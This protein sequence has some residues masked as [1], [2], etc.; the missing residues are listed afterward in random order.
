GASGPASAEQWNAIV[1]AAEKEGKVTLYNAATPSIQMRIKA[2]FEKAHPRITLE[3]VRYGSGALMAKIDQERSMGAEGADVAV[4]TETAWF[5]RHG[6]QGLV[7]A[8]VGPARAGWPANFLLNGMTPILTMEPIVMMVNTNLVKTPVTGQKDLIRP[9]FKGRIGVED[10]ASTFV[11]AWYD[12]VEKS[13]EPGYLAK[14]A[15][16]QPR[17]YASTVA[18]AQSVSAGE[19]AIANF[20][21]MGAALDAVSKGA[22]VR[23]VMP[24]PA[25]ANQYNAAILGWAR[26]SNAAQVLVNFLM[27]PAGQESWSGDGAS[28]SPLPNIPNALDARVMRSVDL[29]PYTPEFTKS[30]RVRFESM[31]KR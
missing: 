21:N 13:E 24:N 14:L 23:V 31:F 27:S 30:Y 7:K 22:P 18:G 15:A 16:Q 12:L 20:V 29:T 9:E 3:W 28:G 11:F 8:P 26:R 19:I 2:A 4:S 17:I 10:L 6:K 25:F 5:D 1:A